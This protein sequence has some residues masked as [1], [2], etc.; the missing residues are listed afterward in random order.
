MSF[1]A[2]E[3]ER[4]YGLGQHQ[5]GKLDQKGLVVDLAQY[6]TEVAIPFLLSSR[7]YGFIWN[8]PSRGRVELS[9]DKTR[10]YAEATKQV[11]YMVVSGMN[12]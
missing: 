7:N 5:H 4:L 6:N 12:R 1:N 8:V 2:Y 10:W 3:G 11:D 9:A